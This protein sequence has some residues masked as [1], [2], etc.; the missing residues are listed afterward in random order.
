MEENNVDKNLLVKKKSQIPKKDINWFDKTINFIYWLLPLYSNITYLKYN[1]NSTICYLFESMRFIFLISAGTCIIYI[2]LIFNHLSNGKK[3][4]GNDKCKYGFPCH[5][6]YSSYD[7]N[8]FNKYSVSYGVWIIVYF[9]CSFIFYCVMYSKNYQ[10]NIYRNNNK[11]QTIS[12]HFFNSWN[13]QVINNKRAKFESNDIYSDLREAKN[14]IFL[15]YNGKMKKYKCRHKCYFFWANFIAVI[16]EIVYLLLLSYSY[17][18]RNTLRNTKKFINK[19]E[20]KDS[21]ADFVFYIIVIGS[22]FFFPFIISLTVKLEPYKK[23]EDVYLVKSFKKII[24]VILG[25]IL[26][27]LEEVS[28]TLK[29]N[30][31]KN[32]D[33]APTFYNCPGKY[34]NKTAETNLDLTGYT[35]MKGNEYAS[36]RE[37]A[38]AVNF[39]FILFSYILLYF[40]IELIQLGIYKVLCKKKLYEFDPIYTFVNFFFINVL[41]SFTII[42]FPVISLT[43]PFVMFGLFKYEFYKLK[44]FANC[45]FDETSIKNLSNAKKILNYFFIF[46]LLTLL[47]ITYLYAT[48]LP[49]FNQIACYNNGSETI[50]AIVSDKICGPT[51]YNGRISFGMSFRMRSAFFFGWIYRL[52][53][54]A[55]SVMILLSIIFIIFIY[56]KYTPSKDYYDFVI[57]KQIEL[58]DTFQLLYQQISK[59][60]FIT[61]NLLAVVKEDTKED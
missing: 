7:I 22:F 1:F 20:S 37:D 32:L 45:K 27:F 8:E 48:R 5:W 58:L 55:I 26:F 42:F 60:D 40:L 14:E 34:L 29:G 11:Y 56:R 50:M 3:Y 41:F 17:N 18:I 59:R 51:F 25:L 4:K 44:L 28:Y 54:E 13:F 52:S 43:F 36:C 47:G 19:A 46:N 35:K 57:N 21:I 12:A 15:K 24:T 2:I 6:F 31:N 16:L 53:R 10:E 30:Q 49:H 23:R 9:S 33:K 39:F 38:F 61:K